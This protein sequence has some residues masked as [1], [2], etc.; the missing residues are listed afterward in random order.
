MG[1]L[2]FGLR[3][4]EELQLKGIA[5]LGSASPK[6]FWL[7]SCISLLICEMGVTPLT[8]PAE[9]AIASKYVAAWCPKER[10]Q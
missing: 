9:L 10:L 2:G 6:F 7:F 8:W 4:K 3:S 1:L 5:A